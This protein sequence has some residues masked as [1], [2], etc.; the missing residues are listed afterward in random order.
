M[1]GTRIDL[2]VPGSCHQCGA[3]HYRNARPT[4]GGLVVRGDE[5]LLLQR[6]IEPWRGHWDIPG[7]FCDGAEL[8]EHTVVRELREET[9][10]HVEVVTLL[11]MWLDVYHLAGTSFDTLNSY[12]LLD[13]GPDPQPVLDAENSAAGWFTA[14]QIPDDIA[15]PSHQKDVIAAW[16][17]WVADRA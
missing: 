1:C 3:A 8:P 9:R 16:Q 5:V 17:R 11:G 15:F 7:G 10:M 2:T 4:A 14:A 13:A 6:A 12:Y